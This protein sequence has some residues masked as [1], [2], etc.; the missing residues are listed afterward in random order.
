MSDI[1]E[2]LRAMDDEQF[3]GGPKSGYLTCQEAADTIERLRAALTDMIDL[4]ETAVGDT[5]A[6]T[7]YLPRFKHAREANK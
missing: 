5:A 3:F 2:R 4:A 7:T 6:Y 1:V